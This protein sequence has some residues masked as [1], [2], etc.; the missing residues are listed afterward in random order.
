MGTT[1]VKS[2]AITLALITPLHRATSTFMRCEQPF[3]ICT[4]QLDILERIDTLYSIWRNST[5]LREIGLAALI[6]LRFSPPGLS[7]LLPVG[8]PR[9]LIR[10]LWTRR[11]RF[12]LRCVV[13]HTLCWTCKQQMKQE[14]KERR[15]PQWCI[16][17]LPCTR[18]DDTACSPKRG[19]KVTNDQQNAYAILCS[20]GSVL[21]N[22]SRGNSL[23]EGKSR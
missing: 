19:A 13:L 11:E 4:A 21:P 6:N 1:Q 22:L 14:T 5:T 3:H 12:S 18:D 2:H 23:I 9:G 16:H 8:F 20:H 15:I 10:W 7:L 17:S